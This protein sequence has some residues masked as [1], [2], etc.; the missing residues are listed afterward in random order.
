MISVITLTYKRAWLLEEAI[1]SCLAQPKNILSEMVII[2]DNPESELIFD[3]PNVR[4]INLN[5]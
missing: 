4:I 5:I 3:H 2:N 1:Y